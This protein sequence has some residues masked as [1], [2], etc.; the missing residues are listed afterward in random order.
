MSKVEVSG[1]VEG[2]YAP[3]RDAFASN[4]AG[5]QEN[6]AAFCM[7]I[8]GKPVVDIWA[9]YADEAQSKPWEI[10]RAHV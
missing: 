4:F 3:V 1:T 8:E 7:T 5:G 10:G 6:G 2:R 9:G